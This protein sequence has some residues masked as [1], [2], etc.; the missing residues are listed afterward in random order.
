MKRTILMTAAL[1]LAATTVA[2]PAEAADKTIQLKSP[3]GS[4]HAVLNWDDSVDTLCLTLKSTAGSP[5][6][7]A[8]MRLADGSHARTLS[9]SPSKRKACTGNLSIPEDRLGEM[10]VYGSTDR[11]SDTS[12]WKP[13]YT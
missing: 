8:D 11:W 5:H 3:S 12:G 13:F 4:V 10:R 1:T 7:S 9:A 2:A 6:A